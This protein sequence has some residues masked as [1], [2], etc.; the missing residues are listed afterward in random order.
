MQLRYQVIELP[1]EFTFTI[2]R[3]S[4]SST[5]VIIIEIDYQYEGRIITGLGEAV[6]VRFYGE[7]EESVLKFFEQI[8]SDKTLAGL[9]PMNL[10][11][12]EKRLAKYSANN[13]AKAAIEIAMHDIRGKIL[14][15][16]LYEILGLDASLCPRTSYTIGIADI[17]TVI[18]KT[19]TAL[20]RGLNILKI[21]LG[22]KQDMEIVKSIRNFAPSALIRVDANAAWTLPEALAMCEE[23]AE[24]NIEFVEE[25]LKLEESDESR[26]E[27]KHCSPLPIMADESCHK[28][29]DIASCARLFHMINLKLPKTGGINEALRMI[30]AAKAHDLKVMLGCFT[31]TSISISAFAHISPL[32]DYADLDGSLLLKNDPY[33]GLSF[34]GDQIILPSDPGIGVKAISL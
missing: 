25:P 20:D 2:S 29:T 14:K 27:L 3:S 1:L 12:L 5:R 26:L 17:D 19:K 24:Y 28:L 18:H 22:S 6:F 32:A 8:N 30:A 9:N 4:S 16:P 34:K 23:L 11:D 13:A 33:K 10:Q 31:E 7:T 21:K 15:R